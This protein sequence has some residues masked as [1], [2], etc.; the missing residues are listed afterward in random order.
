MD[1][2]GRKVVVCDNGTGVSAHWRGPNGHR[3]GRECAE[4]A[5]APGS[6]AFRL[7]PRAAGAEELGAA[8]FASAD[9]GSER[10]ESGL[11]SSTLPPPQPPGQGGGETGSGWGCRLLPGRDGLRALAR[12][13]WRKGPRGKTLGLCVRKGL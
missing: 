4:D 9:E 7:G 10:A 2:Q 12:A 1:S 5:W 8:L 11:F 13:I 3:P 6:G